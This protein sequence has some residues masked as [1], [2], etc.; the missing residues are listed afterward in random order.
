MRTRSGSWIE[1]TDALQRAPEGAAQVNAAMLAVIALV[2]AA[3][4]G[5]VQDARLDRL[6]KVRGL[7]EQAHTDMGRVVDPHSRGAPLSREAGRGE[8]AKVNKALKR[9]E[10]VLG[11]LETMVIE[12]SGDI[13]EVES[14]TGVSYTDVSVAAE[15]IDERIDLL[16]RAFPEFYEDVRDAARGEE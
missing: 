3:E 9:I 15:A 4:N 16:A 8:V 2:H 1:G 14:M 11:R 12:L 7:L 5:G 6:I 13:A 10:T